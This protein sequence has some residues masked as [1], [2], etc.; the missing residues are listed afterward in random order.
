[1]MK[2]PAK[3]STPAAANAAIAPADAAFDEVV[4]LIHAA[5]QRA[6][7][8]VNTELIDLYWSIGA[9]LHHK[10]DANGWA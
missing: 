7:Q 9:S 1:M 4:S 10:I 8:A 2:K 3:R 5:R 6:V